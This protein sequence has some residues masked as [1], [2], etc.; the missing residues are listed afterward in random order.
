LGF[1]LGGNFFQKNYH[2]ERAKK[3]LRQIFLGQI[4]WNKFFGK[5]FLGKRKGK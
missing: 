2:L 1:E 4:F 3:D 5:N